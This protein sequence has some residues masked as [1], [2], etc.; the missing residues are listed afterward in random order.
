MTFEVRET[1]SNAE[2]MQQLQDGSV[3][4]ITDFYYDYNWGRAN[5]VDVTF[6]YLD[7]KYVAILRR[8]DALPERPRVACIRGH[9]YTHSFVEKQYEADQLL[10]FDTLQQ[11]LQAVSA[12]AADITFTKAIT[13]Q[14]DILKGNYYDL[15]TN[16]NVV[17]SHKVPWG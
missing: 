2:V 5:H 6:P 4:I 10:Y 16:G 12:G 3:D 1:A 17:F 9:Y 8:N 14:E 13:A 15:V 11:C 7:L